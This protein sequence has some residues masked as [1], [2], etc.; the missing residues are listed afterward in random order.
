[1]SGILIRHFRTNSTPQ[2]VLD[3]DGGA[4]FVVS[5]LRHCVVSRISRDTGDMVSFGRCGRGDGE[6]VNPVALALVVRPGRNELVVLDMGNI[7][8]FEVFSV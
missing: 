4:S 6:F 7:V 1:M 3:C 5:D 2:D 8:R